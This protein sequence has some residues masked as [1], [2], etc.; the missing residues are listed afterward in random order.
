MARECQSEFRM[1]LILQVRFSGDGSYIF[2]GSDDMNLRVWKVCIM[3]PWP[4]II[5]GSWQAT[6]SGPFFLWSAGLN[7]F[8]QSFS[9][10]VLLWSAA[11]LECPGLTSMSWRE[12]WG[13]L[14][15]YGLFSFRDPRGSLSIFRPRHRS[16]K[17][18]CYRGNATNLPTT[19]PS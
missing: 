18:C 15:C 9:S 16:S 12:L 10:P 14:V 3:K 17:V 6:E 4:T 5:P 8:A 7:K 11:I 1:W 2:S 19:K 13:W